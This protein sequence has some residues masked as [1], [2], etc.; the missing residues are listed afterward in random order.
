LELFDWFVQATLVELDLLG[1]LRRAQMLQTVLFGAV[2]QQQ[3]LTA[4]DQFGQLLLPVAARR[5]GRGL[6][7]LSKLGEHGGIQCVGLGEGEW[8]PL[9]RL[10]REGVRV[11]VEVCDINSDM[12]GVGADG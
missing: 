2:H 1:Q 3:L 4:A 8:T 10:W 5:C 7:S 6:Q 12:D 9:R 11:K